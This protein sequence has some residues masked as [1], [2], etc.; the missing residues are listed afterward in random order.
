MTWEGYRYDDDEDDEPEDFRTM[1]LGEL[2]ARFWPHPV[3][4]MMVVPPAG[5]EP[6]RNP[7]GGEAKPPDGAPDP[8]GGE[9]LPAA[10]GDM[11]DQTADEDRGDRKAEPADEA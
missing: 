7:G 10:V 8:D 9:K 6:A 1:P 2:L 11:G 5:I 3:I 4:Q